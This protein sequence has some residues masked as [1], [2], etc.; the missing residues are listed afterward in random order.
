MNKKKIEQEGYCLQS[1][2]LIDY[3]RTKLI[4]IDDFRDYRYW[5]NKLKELKQKVDSIYWKI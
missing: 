3:L 2:V 1:K 5:D 4:L